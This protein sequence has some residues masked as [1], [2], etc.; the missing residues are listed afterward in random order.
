MYQLVN[1]GTHS[2]TPTS[3]LARLRRAQGGASH[4]PPWAVPAKSWHAGWPDKRQAACT[5]AVSARPGGEEDGLL[6]APADDER[7]QLGHETP[8]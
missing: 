5:R 8:A 7:L 3:A 4:G 2:L 1:K 6:A